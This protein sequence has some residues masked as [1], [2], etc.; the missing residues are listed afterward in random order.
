MKGIAKKFKIGDIESLFYFYIGF[1]LLSEVFVIF[2]FKKVSLVLD[3]PLD[4]WSCFFLLLIVPLVET[5]LLGLITEAF[6]YIFFMNE[7][8]HK[9]N[10]FA[11]F[12]SKTKMPF[13]V[14]LLLLTLFIYVLL[15]I[16]EI[17]NFIIGSG[18]FVI[19]LFLTI[20]VIFFVGIFMLLVLKLFLSYKLKLKILRYQFEFEQQE[21][22]NLN[23]CR[24][25][26]H[27]LPKS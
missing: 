26:V 25:E 27:S 14:I 5:F 3:I 13:I 6:N 18:T 23:I 10:F 11:L 24:K 1:I 9:N 7:S 17:L 12:V 20:V 22:D 15:N 4:F 21:V 16:D 2:M 19:N 8:I